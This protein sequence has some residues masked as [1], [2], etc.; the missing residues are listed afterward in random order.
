MES[1]IVFFIVGASLC[2][3]CSLIGLLYNIYVQRRVKD[4]TMLILA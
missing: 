2:V 4:E 3:F 1:N